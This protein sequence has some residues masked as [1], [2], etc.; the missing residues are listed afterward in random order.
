MAQWNFDYDVSILKTMVGGDSS[1]DSPRLF[2]ENFEDAYAFLKSYGFDLHDPKHEKRTWYYHM[3]ALAFLR[4]KILEKHE[5]I[6]PTPP[7]PST[8]TKKCILQ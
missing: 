7:I 8:R 5:E 6:P 3:R 1:L 2:V 4:E